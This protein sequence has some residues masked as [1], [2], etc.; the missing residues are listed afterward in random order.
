MDKSAY[1]AGDRR[2]SGNAADGEWYCRRNRQVSGPMP[3]ETLVRLIRQ[4]SLGRH[5]EVRLAGDEAWIKVA[6]VAELLTAGASS[7]D[8][9]AHTANSETAA[10]AAATVLATVDLSVP[11]HG[12]AHRSAPQ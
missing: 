2:S 12:G 9:A 1:R 3:T 5:D 6:D 7:A 4:R 10:S 8:Q 11:L